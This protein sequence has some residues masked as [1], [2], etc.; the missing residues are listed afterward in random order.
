MKV[1]GITIIRNAIRFD[2]PVL[3][4]IN[5]ILP[6]VDKMF[7]G[8]GNSEDETKL[9][10][11]SINSPKIQIIDSVWDDTLR[12]GG[13]VLAVET[14]KVLD[15]VPAEF[16]WIVYIQA[17][18]VIHEDGIGEIQQAM[19]KALSDKSVEALLLKYLHFYGHYRYLGDSRRW[20]RREIRVVKNIAGLRSFR[21]AQG[22]RINNRLIRVKLVEAYVYHYGWV[23]NPRIQLEKDK[24]FQKL[25]HKD[26]ALNRKMVIADEYDYR[27]IDSLA[28]FTGTHPYVMHPRIQK[29]DW[30]FQFDTSKKNFSLKDKALYLIEKLTGYRFFE[31]KN[32]K[33]I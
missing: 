29:A 28:I 25:W 3:E 20:Y 18:E 5:S 9:L 24:S 6:L 33:I 17:D 15:V 8:V 13:R 23:K 14:N 11:Q 4:S 21:D 12:D 32:Y 7:V 27:N 31:Y 30:D 22:F 19:H 26:S 2:Y 1:A 16:D 10:I